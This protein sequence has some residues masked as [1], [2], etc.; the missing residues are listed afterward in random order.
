MGHPSSLPGALP[1][2]VFLVHPL[3]LVA[4]WGPLLAPWGLGVHN[5]VSNGFI[6]IHL[7]RSFKVKMQL[8]TFALAM[9]A[10]LLLIYLF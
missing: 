10:T 3:R 2:L 6:L 4:L 1:V 5:I 8:H 7:A 9:G